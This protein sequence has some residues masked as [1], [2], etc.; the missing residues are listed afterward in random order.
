MENKCSFSKLVGG[1]CGLDTKYPRNTDNI[2]LALC[3]RDIGPHISK[4]GI[5][6][7]STEV[8][9]ILAR[10]SIF[11]KPPT[12]AELTIC[13][14]HRCHLGTSWRRGADRCC[15]PDGH[16][17]HKQRRNARRGVGKLESKF[18]LRATGVFVPVG[19]GICRDCIQVTHAAIPSNIQSDTSMTTPPTTPTAEPTEDITR[20]LANI[21]MEVLAPIP[22]TPGYV[23]ALSDVIVA[24]SGHEDMD[25]CKNTQDRLRTSKRYL[26]S[27]YKKDVTVFKNEIWVVFND[28][29]SPKY[30]SKQVI[31]RLK[32]LVGTS[33]K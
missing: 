2:P 3:K 13:P 11:S 19:S 32:L 16:S 27:D 5:S 17:K 6:D 14:L 20:A 23:P 18:I 28:F 12:F 9:L 10:A 22:E 25:W 29:W 26:K 15:V 31:I 30:L 24:D 33:R 4:F 7:I 8:E 21:S 1:P